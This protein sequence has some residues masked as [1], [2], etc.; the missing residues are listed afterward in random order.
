[1]S[2]LI[3]GRRSIPDGGWSGPLCCAKKPLFPSQDAL[4]GFWVKGVQRTAVDFQGHAGVVL[5]PA[6]NE[7]I[8]PGF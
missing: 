8:E 2:R 4:G 6:R 3:R 5:R 7:S 1:M